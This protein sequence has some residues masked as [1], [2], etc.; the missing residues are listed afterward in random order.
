MAITVAV[1]VVEFT[2][3]GPFVVSFNLSVPTASVDAMSHRKNTK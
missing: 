1:A 3:I 2:R